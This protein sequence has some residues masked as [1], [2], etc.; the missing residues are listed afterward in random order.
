M[1]H[2]QQPALLWI[3]KTERNPDRLFWKCG[4]ARSHQC[5]FF[6]WLISQPLRQDLMGSSNMEY[7]T[8]KKQELCPHKRT[9]KEGSNGI[10]SKVRCKDCGKMLKDELTEAGLKI[11]QA[12][13]A[14]QEEK[15]WSS[16]ESQ[17]KMEQDNKDFQEFLMWRRS[18]QPHHPAVEQPEQSS[19][20]Q[21]N[22]LFM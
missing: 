21:R 16:M 9:T 3:S 12:R 10:N 4:Q 6:Q 15:S 20:S 11:H 7:F 2:C 22:G 8:K 1:C 5:S 18:Q 14:K 17:A 13:A 19:S